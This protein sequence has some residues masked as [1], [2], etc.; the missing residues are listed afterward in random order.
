MNRSGSTMQ[1][2]SGTVEVHGAINLDQFYYRGGLSDADTVKIELTV[3]SVRFRPTKQSPWKENLEV[4]GEGYVKGNPVVDGQNRITVRLQGIDAPEL[5]YHANRGIPEKEMT[6]E[7]KERWKN[8]EYRQWWSAI[9]T[10]KLATFLNAYEELQGFGIVR[11]I[12]YSRVDSPSDV[13]DIY[14]R[15]VGD[16]IMPKAPRKISNI[17]QWLSNEGWAFPTFYNSMS[18]DEITT[19]LNISK[20]AKARKKGVW[21]MYADLLIPFDDELYLPG[22]NEPLVDVLEDNGGLNLP[23]IFRRQVQYEVNKRAGIYKEPTLKKYL[24]KSKDYCYNTADFLNDNMHVEKR[25]LGEFVDSKGT[26]IVEPWE[27]LFIEKPA[28]LTDLNKNKIETWY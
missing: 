20:K 28:D 8:K 19:L 10:W 11:A 25:N 21:K 15:F 3:E 23:K 22:K 16:I 18:N 9:A 4:F 6:A 24:S 13:F 2:Y 17:N 7:Q 1:N 26:L 5:H 14:G 12:A 27:F